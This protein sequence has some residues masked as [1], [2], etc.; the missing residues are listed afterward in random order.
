MKEYELTQRLKTRHEK[1]G[2]KR[3]T[4]A[5]H[6]CGKELKIGEKVIS[7]MMQSG[8]GSK[9]ILYHEECYW[10]MFINA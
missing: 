9:T 4:C 7:R 2:R 8:H 10:K 3:L 6:K 5:Y 1:R